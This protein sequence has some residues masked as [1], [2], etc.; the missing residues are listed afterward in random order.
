MKPQSPAS[1]ETENTIGS[2]GPSVRPLLLSV[3]V[4]IV[5]LPLTL[6]A[7]SAVIQSNSCSVT[8]DFIGGQ[9][10][11]QTGPLLLALTPGILNLAPALWVMSHHKRTRFAAITASPL[12]CARLAIPAIA[13]AAGGTTTYVSWGLYPAFPNQGGAVFG[14]G[15]ISLTSASLWLATLAAMTAFA[16]ANR[17]HVR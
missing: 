10:M 6:I 11:C 15:A 3:L 7:T 4:P 13:L 5:T 8:L 14:V 12:G 16:S 9:A 17:R 2:K 1:P